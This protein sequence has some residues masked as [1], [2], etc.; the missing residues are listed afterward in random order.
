MINRIAVVGSRGFDSYSFFAEKLEQIISN[1]DGEIEYISGGCKSGADA[2]ISRYCK[3]HNYKLTE[4]L[5]DWEQY[6]KSAGMIRNK[7]II[8]DATHIIAFWDGVSKGTANSLK[9]AEKRK[10]PIRIVKI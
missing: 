5:P 8:N 2:L 4:Y 10:L 3:E 1:L 9:L 6:K 7:L